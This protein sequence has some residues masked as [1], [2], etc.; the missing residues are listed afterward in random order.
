[1]RLSAVAFVLVAIAG[2][3]QTWPP[4]LGISHMAVYTSDPAKA[5]HFYVQQSG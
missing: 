1:M 4:I 5:E 3:A 2:A